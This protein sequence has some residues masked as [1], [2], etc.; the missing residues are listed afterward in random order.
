MTP[1]YLAEILRINRLKFPKPLV[2]DDLNL[3]EDLLHNTLEDNL[4]FSPNGK[5]INVSSLST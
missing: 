5:S 4:E 2:Y 3:D 1:V